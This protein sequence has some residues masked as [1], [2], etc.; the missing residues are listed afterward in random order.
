LYVGTM[1]SDEVSTCVAGDLV[2]W[3]SMADE[4]SVGGTWSGDGG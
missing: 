3:V 4:E 2:G 1:T